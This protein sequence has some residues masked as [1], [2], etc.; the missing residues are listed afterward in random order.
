MIGDTHVEND[1]TFSL[2]LSAPTNAVIQDGQAT[3]TI[4]NDDMEENTNQ[5][6]LPSITR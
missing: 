4:L 2:I 3:G 5:I 6:Y 1:E